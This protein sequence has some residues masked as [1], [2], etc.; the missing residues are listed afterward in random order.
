MDPVITHMERFPID[1]DN[2]KAM[3]PLV[4]RKVG[5]VK[6]AKAADRIG[7]GYLSIHI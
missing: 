3:V 5:R 1:I 2:G 6:L 7:R 4:D